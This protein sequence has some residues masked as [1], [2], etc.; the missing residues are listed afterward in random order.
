M[1]IC[2]G[3]NRVRET[4]ATRRRNVDCPSIVVC[5]NRCK[6]ND[7]TNRVRRLLFKRAFGRFVTPIESK[8][9]SAKRLA[10]TNGL[11]RLHLNYHEEDAFIALPD[12]GTEYRR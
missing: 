8:F 7:R 4:S 6:R 11:P 3:G 5:S 9:L 12:R 10:A 1:A 2:Y